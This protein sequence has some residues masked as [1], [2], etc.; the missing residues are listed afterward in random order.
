MFRGTMLMLRA[1]RT[2]P[3]LGRPGY[4]LASGAALGAIA[5]ALVGYGLGGAWGMAPVAFPFALLGGAGGL[6]CRWLVASRIRTIGEGGFETA[7]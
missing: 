5:G 7:A 1:A 3:Q 4:W 6:W 2:D